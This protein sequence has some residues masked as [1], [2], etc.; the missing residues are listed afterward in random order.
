[1]VKPAYQDLALDVWLHCR[2]LGS[3]P[4]NLCFYHDRPEVGLALLHAM[5]EIRDGGVPGKLTLTFAKSARPKAIEKLS[6]LYEAESPD[7]KVMQVSGTSPAATIR[8]TEQGLTLLDA[9]FRKWLDGLEDFG[10]GPESSKLNE[11]E[12]GP[13]DR[14]SHEIWF[15]G[16]MYM[17]P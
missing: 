7:L 15:W 10:V 17:A 6:L 11:K 4:R 9:T 3:A 2:K 14:T 1:M 16:P 13:F 5:A 12:L 8:F